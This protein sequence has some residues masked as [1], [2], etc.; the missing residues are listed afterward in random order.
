M[1]GSFLRMT[2]LRSVDI[3]I[4]L[5]VRKYKR[6]QKEDARHLGVIAKIGAFVCGLFFSGAL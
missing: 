6:E 2:I 1:E 5:S 4:L 3:A